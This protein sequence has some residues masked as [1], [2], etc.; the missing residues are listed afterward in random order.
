[1]DRKK[2]TRYEKITINLTV[3]NQFKNPQSMQDISDYFQID[4]SGAS[5]MVNALFHQGLIYISLDT[6]FKPYSFELTDRGIWFLD[7]FY[8]RVNGEKE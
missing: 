1:L 5:R 8:P 2:Q 6:D 7:T 3:L 4:F